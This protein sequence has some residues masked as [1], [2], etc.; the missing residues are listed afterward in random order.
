MAKK[1]KGKGGKGLTFM[2]R[3]DIFTPTSFMTERE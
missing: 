1:T 2:G 3:F